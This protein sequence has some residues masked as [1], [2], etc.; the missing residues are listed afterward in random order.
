VLGRRACSRSPP[1]PRTPATNR[2]QRRPAEG[3]VTGEEEQEKEQAGRDRATETSGKIGLPKRAAARPCTRFTVLSCFIAL[4]ALTRQLLCASVPVYAWFAR[5]SVCVFVRQPHGS[6]ICNPAEKKVCCCERKRRRRRS[7]N[8]EHDILLWE[9]AKC[10]GAGLALGGGRG[11]ARKALRLETRER[12]QTSEAKSKRR[13]P[14][15]LSGR[16]HGTRPASRRIGQFPVKW[17]T[18]PIWPGRRGRSEAGLSVPFESQ[19]Y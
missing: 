3:K 2:C 13:R 16:W 14:V 7:R 19:C 8:L 17:H 6:R 15:S 12:V 5:A 1:R 10:E 4:T 11:G 18:L 9:G